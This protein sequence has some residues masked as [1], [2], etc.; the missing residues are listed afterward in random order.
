MKSVFWD[1]VPYGSGQNRRIE[2]QPPFNIHGRKNPEEGG[3]P[4]FQNICSNKPPHGTISQIMAFFIVAAVKISAFT[5]LLLYH[6]NAKICR[7]ARGKE[8]TRK[9]ET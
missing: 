4:F 2:R 7:K 5:C 8:T 3:D 9:T 1:V 6:R